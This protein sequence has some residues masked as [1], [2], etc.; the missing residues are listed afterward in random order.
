MTFPRC[1]P[2][3]CAVLALTFLA[4]VGPGPARAQD[5]DLS[6]LTTRAEASGYEQTTR[7]DE[8]MAF[9]EVAVR[10]SDR[11]H[12]TTFGYTV[13][14]RPLPLVVYGDVADPSP[15][16]VRAAGKTRVFVQA[17]I[18]AGE[19]CGKEA[20]L[21]L[22]RALA[23]GQ[24]RAWAD[25]LV[26]MIA[27]IYNADGNERVSLYH[28][29]RQN[30]PFGG[31]GQRPNAQGLDLNRDHMKL[32]SP[33]ARSLVGLFGRYDPHVVI[34][35]H[36]T[37]GTAHGYHLTY[38]P[39]LHPSTYAPITD[40]LRTDWLPAVTETVRQE[41]GWD[42]YY[43]GNVPREGWDAP[44]GWYTFSHRPRFNNNYVGLRNRFA[45]LSEAYAYASFEERTLATLYFV[46]ALLD[47]A[48]RKAATIREVVAAADAHAVT[49]DTLALKAT[50]ARS[51][52]PTEILM[53][54]VEET[55]H[56]YTGEVVL[57]RR[58]VQQPETMDE[59]GTFTAAQTQV[60][61]ATYYVEPQQEAVLD[62]LA[63]HGV[64]VERLEEA[65][66]LAVEQFRVDSVAVAA[67][68]YQ[69]RRARTLVGRYERAK[70]KLAAGTAVVMTDQPLGRLAFFLLEPESDDG[71]AHWGLLDPVPEAGSVYPIYR[72]P[73][74][75]AAPAPVEEGLGDASGG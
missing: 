74:D 36:T 64:R 75:S 20:M 26:L 58:A 6:F 49:G 32:D 33:E 12:Q 73:T 28:R 46:E 21:M 1:C 2:A 69:G 11:L 38:S 15:E 67:E 59:Y 42:F 30:G 45:I 22:V 17:N 60:V 25:S 47:Y 50:F 63:A 13:E 57:R 34:D 8:L 68:E 9:L 71:L 52:T 35:L 24:H 29:P 31:M 27:P 41:Y 4:T 43:Y 18:H 62:R 10:T 48:A 19:V 56:P 51:E 44:R 55:R 40:L 16:A 7:Y 23:A 70:V 72:A 3:A 61:P 5:V 54:A 66:T 39:P 14:G 53:G 37:N 65:Q